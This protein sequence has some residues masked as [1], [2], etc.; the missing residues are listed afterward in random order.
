MRLAIR[1]LAIALLV[2]SFIF[3]PAVSWAQVSKRVVFAKGKMSVSYRGKLP[4]KYTY[5]DSYVLR[6]KKGQVLSVKLTSKDPDAYFAIYETR[7]LGPEEDAILANDEQSREWSGKLPIKSEYSIQVYGVG[8]IDDVDS[9]G[10][11][12]TIEISLRS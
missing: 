4:R 9:S 8:S 3:S 1:R 10:A 2:G 6:A 12:Y 11:A 7:E 5:Y